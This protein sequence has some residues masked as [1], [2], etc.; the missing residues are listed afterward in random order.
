VVHEAV[1]RRGG[2]HRVLEN[3]LP[4]AEDQVACDEHRAALVALGHQREEHL[5]LVG[6]LLRVREHVDVDA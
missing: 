6:A 4:L 1:D 5:D 2:G 3:L